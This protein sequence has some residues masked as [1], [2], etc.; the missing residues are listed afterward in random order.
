MDNQL[1]FAGLAYSTAISILDQRG[2][3]S[4]HEEL[5]RIELENFFDQN[6]YVFEKETKMDDVVQTAVEL[7]DSNHVKHLIMDYPN[8]CFADAIESEGFL[9]VLDAY[10]VLSVEYPKETQLAA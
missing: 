6:F 5:S 10:Y 2:L 7:L 9:T 3:F 8:K 4:V 1:A